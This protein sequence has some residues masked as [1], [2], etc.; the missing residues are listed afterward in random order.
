MLLSGCYLTREP[1]GYRDEY[2]RP[3]TEIQRRN[4]SNLSS[5]EI[6]NLQRQIEG[7]TKAAIILR[8][9][10]ASLQK[11]SGSLLVSTRLL[12]DKVN[13]LETK[14][15]LT[16]TKQKD[17]EKGIAD[18]RA[19]NKELSH[20]LNEMRT[21]LL[22]ENGNTESSVFSHA[23][24]SS[25]HVQYAE[26]LS[27]FHQ[28]RYEDA[29]GVFKDLKNNGIEDDLEDNC[30]YW[31]GECCFAR[32]EYHEAIISFQKVIA[33]VASN[34]KADAYFMLGRSYEQQG[35]LIKSCWAYGE[36]IAQYP[37]NTHTRTVESRLEAMK[38]TQPTLPDKKSKRTT[39]L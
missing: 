18:L 39:K 31:M 8:D 22:A 30:E 21:R 29:L 26:G 37:G 23:R 12:V 36:F 1:L 33:L 35:D 27:L 13:E 19:E 38:R 28:R 2:F 16:S 14:E 20:Q 34:K 9:S 3:V 15:F 17:V 24:T 5:T 4:H 11:Y 25:F 10:L 7:A 6:E 32:H